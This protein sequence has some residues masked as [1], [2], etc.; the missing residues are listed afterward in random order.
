MR[1]V[2]LQVGE[3]AAEASLD[4]GLAPRTVAALWE[5]LPIRDR[6]IQ[7]RWSGDAWRTEGNYE[8]LSREDPIENVAD[9]LAPGDLIYY[10]GYRAGLL[11]VGAAYGDARWLA[12]FCVPLDVSLIG[13]VDRNLDAFTEACRRIILDGPLTVEIGRIV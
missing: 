10:P 11:K 3:V 9:R 7:T 5:R 4:D 1:R 8:L 12:P 6:T 2:Y 13:R